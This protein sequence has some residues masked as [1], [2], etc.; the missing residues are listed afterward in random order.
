MHIHTYM[1][2]YRKWAENLAK[3]ISVTKQLEKSVI[4]QEK[5]ASKE[6]HSHE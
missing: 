5:R 4:K 2:I 6:E 3:S 1:Y